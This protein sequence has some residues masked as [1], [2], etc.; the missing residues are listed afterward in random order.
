MKLDL[1][2]VQDGAQQRDS[3]HAV[4]RALR[5]LAGR[6]GAFVVAEGIETREQLHLVREL[7]LSAGQGYLLGRPGTNVQL[8]RIDLDALE[9]GA[10]LMQNPNAA[11]EH[12][13]AIGGHDGVT[14]RP[15][16]RECTRPRSP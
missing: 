8:T 16:P 10:L 4:L 2:L 1:S 6:W 7:G 13:A 11:P 9:A 12:P 5:D 3:S 14:R 15:P